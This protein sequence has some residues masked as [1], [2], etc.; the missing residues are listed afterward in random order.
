MFLKWLWARRANHYHHI[1]S[2]L[3]SSSSP[4]S[5]SSSS[6]SSS[7]SSSSSSCSWEK[8]WNKHWN[9]FFEWIMISRWLKPS[10][11]FPQFGG[12]DSPLK[13]SR[14]HHLKKGIAR[15][16]I[17][18]CSKPWLLVLYRGLY[19]PLIW[20]IVINQWISWN[21]RWN[22]WMS[23]QGFVAAAQL[24][25]HLHRHSRLF[26]FQFLS[27]CQAFSPTGQSSQQPQGFKGRQNVEGSPDR[28]I[29]EF[30]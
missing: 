22:V 7:C 20:G 27:I 5:S 12:H 2:C 9:I 6:S 10:P 29:L 4:S 15:L 23:C 19:Y 21:L 11:F 8:K 26:E 3:S 16:T 18:Q 13:G 14:F 24:M 1:S 25:I 30:L 28:M 17:E